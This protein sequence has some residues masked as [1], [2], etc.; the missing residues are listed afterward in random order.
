MTQELGL[1]EQKK[2]RTRRTLADV[3]TRL[4]AERGFDA[5]TIADIAALAGVSQLFGESLGPLLFQLPPFL[6]KDAGLLRE[7]LARLPKLG[8]VAFEFRHRSWFADDTY[9]ALAEGGAALCA[10]DLDET[11]KS[12]PLVRTAPFCY[13]RL[14]RSGYS[15]AELDVWAERL[16][17]EGFE[18]AFGYFKHE[19]LGP[20]LARQMGARF[21]E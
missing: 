10:G 15:E 16:E 13:L 21:N 14:R 12:P 4:F 5:V 20:L 1:R 19:E 8:R 2:L 6:Q 3:A 18:V 7:F 11:A 9:G 17:A